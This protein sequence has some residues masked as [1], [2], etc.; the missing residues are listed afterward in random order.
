[1]GSKKGKEKHIRFLK[2]SSL[3]KGEES[4]MFCDR[5]H[6]GHLITELQEEISSLIKAVALSVCKDC[7][8]HREDKLATLFES[9]LE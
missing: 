4:C 2:I 7:K 1:M 8:K 3:H 5:P 9:N 6:S